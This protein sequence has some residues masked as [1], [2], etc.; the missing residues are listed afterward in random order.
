MECA[1]AA[2]PDGT[3]SR[4][5]D[6][7]LRQDLREYF[8]AEFDRAGL[9]TRGRVGDA[10]SWLIE[11]PAFFGHLKKLAQQGITIYSS[12]EDLAAHA[13]LSCDS[14]D[15]QLPPLALIVVPV[16]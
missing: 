2:L 6:H 7:P 12:A 1:G 14:L 5:I 4:R 3:G 16:M 13:S 11:G 15:H 10:E 8:Q 9:R